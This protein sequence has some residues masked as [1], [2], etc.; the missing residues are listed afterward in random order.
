VGLKSY[1]T[2]ETPREQISPCAALRV[3]ITQMEG[4]TVASVEAG[5]AELKQQMH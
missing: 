3:R 2:A 1:G 5:N 4:A